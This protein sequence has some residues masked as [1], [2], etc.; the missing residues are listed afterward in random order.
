MNKS[1]LLFFF[2]SI[3]LSFS[4][5]KLEFTQSVE[6]PKWEPNRSIILTSGDTITVY[7]PY[8]N[9]GKILLKGQIHCHTTNSDGKLTPEELADLYYEN[10]YDF[11]TITDH[12]FISNEPRN[13]KMVW[14]SDSYEHTDRF[15]ACIYNPRKTFPADGTHINAIYRLAKL[16][17]INTILNYAHPD[18]NPNF[19][20]YQ[21]QTDEMISQVEGVS[22][23]EIFNGAY[24]TARPFDIL[25]SQK[26]KVFGIGVEDFHLLKHLNRGFIKAYVKNK[27][28][29]SIWESLNNGSFFATNGLDVKI[30]MTDN[31]VIHITSEDSCDIS[32]IGKNG[33]IIKKDTNTS[34]SSYRLT[35]D[36]LYVRSE[37]T[38]YKGEICFTQPVFISINKY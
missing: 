8:Y 5:T 7:D 22:F 36:E 23:V 30:H 26:K 20:W 17:N 29:E 2:L 12:N 38:N 19:E 14:I 3:Q 9:S 27:S 4:C 11:W 34:E 35:G 13:N 6:I 37:I 10:G 32:F 33:I 28:V 16:N 31:G 21:Y 18:W 1:S 15:H 24:Q 25:L